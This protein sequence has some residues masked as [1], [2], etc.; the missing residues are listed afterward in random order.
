MSRSLEIAGKVVWIEDGG[1]M[2]FLHS[3]LGEFYLITGCLGYQMLK[4]SR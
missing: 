1:K 4:Q 3:Y 2:S